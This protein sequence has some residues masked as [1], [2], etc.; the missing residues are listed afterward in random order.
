M[1]NSIS[2]FFTFIN[3]SHSKFIV[4]CVYKAL[5]EIIHKQYVINNEK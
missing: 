4:S 3:E 2:T 1:I 5:Y